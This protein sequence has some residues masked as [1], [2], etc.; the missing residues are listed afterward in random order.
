MELEDSYF[1]TLLLTSS[2]LNLSSPFH[3]NGLI[4][5]TFQFNFII[6]YLLTLVHG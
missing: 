6:N 3:L 5:K 2:P 1:I 4:R